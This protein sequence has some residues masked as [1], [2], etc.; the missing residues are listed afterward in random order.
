MT[1]REGVQDESRFG[2][3]QRATLVFA[4]MATAETCLGVFRI[5][6]LSKYLPK[7]KVERLGVFG[8]ILNVLGISFKF[9]DYVNPRDRYDLAI[10]GGVWYAL[11]VTFDATLGRARG[12]SVQQI[13]DTFNPTKG[14]YLGLYMS[15]LF[16]APFI[17]LGIKYRS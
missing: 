9:I 15:V 6:V 11:M 13:C 4:L 5:L 7:D 3:V 2:L 1:I 17:A 16:V 12:L 8:A 10:V 14:G